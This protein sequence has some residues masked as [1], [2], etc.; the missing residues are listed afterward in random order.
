MPIN[1]VIHEKRK[2][3][4]LTQEDMADALGVSVPAVSKWENGISYPD[5]TIIPA[6][7]RFLRTDLN[8]L[9]CYEREL[10]EKEVGAFINDL[11]KGMEQDGFAK[12]YQSAREKMKEYPTDARFIQTTATFLKGAM[13]MSQFKPEE[14]SFYDGEITHLY[15]MVGALDCEPY[16]ARANYMLAANKI[17]EKDYEK[18][19][20]MLDRIPKYDGMDKRILQARIL[21]ARNDYTEAAKI[22]EAKLSNDLNDAQ[23]SLMQLIHIAVIE[24]NNELAEKLVLCGEGIAKTA[25]LWEYNF[26]IFGFQKAV[27]EKDAKKTIKQLKSMLEA[28]MVPWDVKKSPMMSHIAAMQKKQEQDMSN[29]ELQQRSRPMNVGKQMLSGILEDLENNPEYDFLRGEKAFAELLEQYRG[30]A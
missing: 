25:G 16:A 12:I 20:E 10:S 2:K 1:Q 15:E 8:T 3:L 19:Q 18:A 6:L 13:I 11:A 14:K 22:Y 23:M 30:N 9:L 28:M 4:G 26:Y 24:E 21:E 29:A 17:A 5:I 7:A 27:D